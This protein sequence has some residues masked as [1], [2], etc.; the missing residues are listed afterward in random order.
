MGPDY[1]AEIQLL[2]R[3]DEATLESMLGSTIVRAVKQA[4]DINT[5][6]VLAE[7]VA[8]RYS[9]ALLKDNG[10]RRSIIDV[11]DDSVRSNFKNNISSEVSIYEYFSTGYSE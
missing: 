6:S 4:Y 10:R 7:L 8:I 11:L 9:Y 2:K 3:L 5:T 1:S